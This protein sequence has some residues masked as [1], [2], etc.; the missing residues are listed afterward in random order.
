MYTELQAKQ[1]VRER[2]MLWR[3]DQYASPQ[4]KFPLS[5]TPSLSH[6]SYL[7]ISFLYPLIPSPILIYSLHISTLSLQENLREKERDRR[8]QK[9]GG[10]G[11]IGF[12]LTQIFKPRSHTVGI[13]S[14]TEQRDTAWKVGNVNE[15]SYHGLNVLSLFALFYLY[16]VS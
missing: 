3:G 14:A 11:F 8:R 2:G 13:H 6:S 7:L 12:C 16:Y 10:K 1:S 4:Y 9:I 15:T 5:F